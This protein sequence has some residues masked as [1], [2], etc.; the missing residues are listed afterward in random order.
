MLDK[1]IYSNLG[2]NEEL[3]RRNPLYFNKHKYAT[4]IIDLEQTLFISVYYNPN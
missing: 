3:Y 1:D 4:M 2:P